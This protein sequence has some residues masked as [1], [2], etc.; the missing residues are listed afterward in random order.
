MIF[1]ACGQPL[2]YA[3]STALAQTER[4]IAMHGADVRVRCEGRTWLV[5]R[6][7][8][9]LH[10][11]RAADLPN[12]KFPEL[13]PR[14]AIYL[15]YIHDSGGTVINLAKPDYTDQIF[16]HRDLDG[17]Y[18]HFH[19]PKLAAMISRQT[20]D[21][22]HFGEFEVTAEMAAIIANGHGIEA[23]HLATRISEEFLHTPGIM[24]AFADGTQL[25]VDGN[26]RFVK[27]AQC[28]LQFMQFWLLPET[29]WR[30]ALVALPAVLE[31]C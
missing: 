17:A 4:L 28:G 21:Q 24:C 14:N 18:R 25:L 9:A 27:R 6:H 3:N 8:I 11:L 12:L 31:M 1:C 16:S 13:L 10:G 15:P 29:A 5:Q 26:H 22:F 19:I 20:T 7:Y 23:E 2:H 30:N